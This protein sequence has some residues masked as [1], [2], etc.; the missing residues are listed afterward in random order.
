MTV[1]KLAL[2]S[3]L[4]LGGLASIAVSAADAQR[5]VRE[6]QREKERQRPKQSQIPQLTPAENAA[7]LPVYQAVQAQNWPAA[8]EALPAARAAAQG[9]QAKYVVGQLQ[10]EIGRNTQNNQLQLEAVEAMLAS[11]VAPADQVGPLL[12]NQVSFALRASNM[13]M[14]EAALARIIEREPNNAVRLTQLAEVKIHLNK[15][16]EA[17]AL[18]QRAIQL[19]EASG[20]KPEE[21]I[22]R[23][24][25]ALAYEARQAEATIALGRSMIQAYPTP[26]NWRSV[27]LAYRQQHQS[28]AALQ[29]DARRFM[30][31]ARLFRDAGEYVAFADSLNRTGQVGE[32]KAVIEEG[33]AARALQAG[34]ADAR[35]LLAA[36]NG[37]IR[38]DQ[39]S[40]PGQ[41]T[42]ALA[43]AT[44]R[45]ARQLGDAYFGYG[46][47]ADAAA[48]YRAALEKG[49][50]DANLVNTRLGA[51][52]AL[53]GR[54]AESE[55]VLRAV[56]GPRAEL[57]QFWLLW[58][59][60]RPAS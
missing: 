57:A 32:V 42:S 11:G 31:A 20:Q 35:T 53:A 3:L 30:R 23:R 41:R 60:S 56:T 6:T 24:A 48:L 22:Y 17:A 44:G 47:Y 54:R 43:G 27:V 2:A 1:S 28:D 36:A 16:G 46:Q 13:P 59:A 38:E 58:L 19:G 5:G 15:R 29:M 33:I 18:F 45:P 21:D 34:D 51:A 9:Q 12:S 52:L 10:Y 37:R 4:A 26:A 8:G 14:A 50:E 25:F 40:L 7:I 55:T 39:A 49:G